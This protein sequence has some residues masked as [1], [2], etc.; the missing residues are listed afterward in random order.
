MAISFET[1]VCSVVAPGA[2]E[3]VVTPYS[4]QSLRV[5]DA[6]SAHLVDVS[7]LGQAVGSQRIDSPLLHDSVFGITTG[8]AAIVDSLM[9]PVEQRL[10][11]QDDLT[12]AI[13]GSATAGDQELIALHIRYN[14]LAG[15]D[16]SFISSAELLKY[17]EHHYSFPVTLPVGS[18]DYGSQ[19]AINNDADELRANRY[20]AII[21]ISPPLAGVFGVS[22]VSPDWGNLRVFA[23]RRNQGPNRPYFT[24]LSRQSGL[25]CIPVFN[26]SQKES[27]LLS[28]VNNEVA[29]GDQ[30]VFVHTLLLKGYKA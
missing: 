15:I 2:T 10:V 13:A 22:F 18:D 14:D 21:G 28:C 9:L 12:V 20:Y 30:S 19:V 26:A 3:S 24:E 29:S 1:I 6:V 11:N 16:G 4:G 5:R 17:A 25:A 8:R 23:P 27:V 7:Y